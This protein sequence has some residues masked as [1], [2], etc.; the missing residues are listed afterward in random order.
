MALLVARKIIVN[1]IEYPVGSLLPAGEL[2]QAKEQSLRASRWIRELEVSDLDDLP[3][4]R[5]PHA[6]VVP[7]PVLDRARATA[8]AAYDAYE[9]AQAE[10]DTLEARQEQVEA[11]RADE[12]VAADERATERRQLL[13][14]EAQAQES[15]DELASTD[16]TDT[17]DTPAEDTE[18][19]DDTEDDDASEGPDDEDGDGMPDFLGGDAP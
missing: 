10:Y 9:I 1:G 11:D 3:Q 7:K 5:V 17:E 12:R 19:N 14:D 4:P 16:D 18:E 13:L 2:T 15:A 6:T 8:Q